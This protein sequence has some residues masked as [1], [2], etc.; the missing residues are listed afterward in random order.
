MGKEEG[1]GL[2]IGECQYLRFCQRKKRWRNCGQW[3]KER[4]VSC[5]KN[6]EESVQRGGGHQWLATDWVTKCELKTSLTYLCAPSRSCNREGG[7]LRRLAVNRGTWGVGVTPLPSLLNT[8]KRPYKGTGFEANCEDLGRNILISIFMTNSREIWKVTP[9]ALLSTTH[10]HGT[11]L[12][13]TGR[14]QCCVHIKMWVHESN[15][16]FLNLKDQIVSFNCISQIDF[17][18]AELFAV[19]TKSLHSIQARWMGHL[20]ICRWS[21]PLWQHFGNHV[22]V[23]KRLSQQRFT[24][25]VMM[26]FSK[27]HEEIYQLHFQGLIWS[28]SHGCTVCILLLEAPMD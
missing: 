5:K 24:K 18:A 17:K 14:L 19:L 28:A 6:R 15:W 16:W 10:L 22:I 11:L 25:P 21:F 9:Y 2:E 12:E 1:W 8:C 23:L 4:V 13:G 7:G 20:G 26:N 3:W 27:A